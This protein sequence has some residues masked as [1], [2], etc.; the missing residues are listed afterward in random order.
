MTLKR[1]DMN[2]FDLDANI[3]VNPVNC[4]GVMGAG[5]AKAFKDRYPHNFNIY[6][7]TCQNKLLKPGGVL[8]TYCCGKTILNVATKGDWRKPSQI[9]WIEKG[10]KNI[11]KHLLTCDKM[12]LA[13]PLLGCGLGGLNFENQVKPLYKTYLEGIGDNQVV[14]SFWKR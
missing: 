5:L 12:V 2:L 9:E 11:R 6:Y 14:V 10:L 13:I 8:V 1:T 7:L 3:Y 4:V